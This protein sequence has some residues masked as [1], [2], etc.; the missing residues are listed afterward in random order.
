MSIISKKTIRQ[1]LQ[2][3]TRYA[4]QRISHLTLPSQSIACVVIVL[5][6]TLWSTTSMAFPSEKGGDGWTFELGFGGEWESQFA[7]SDNRQFEP[8]PYFNIAYRNGKSIWYTNITDYGVYSSLNEKWIAGVSAGLEVGRDEDD[9]EALTGLGNIDDTWELRFDLAYRVSDQLTI[10]GRAM[11]AGAD[12]DNVLFIA[13][14]YDIPLE[15]NRFKLTLKTD[16]SWGTRQHMQTEF[17]VSAEQ[18]VSSGY[19]TYEPDSGI[20]S[21]GAGIAAKYRVDDHW[22]GYG[23]VNFEK[24]ADAGS[25]SPFAQ[26]DYDIEAEIGIGYRF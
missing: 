3:A 24:Y 8:D 22:F 19:A 13:A 16:I 25:D 26:N 11:T 23:D 10:A 20:K 5:V 14:L 9:D 7:G 17:G 6:C 12:K 18:S 21:V 2:H 15:L 4:N 1:L